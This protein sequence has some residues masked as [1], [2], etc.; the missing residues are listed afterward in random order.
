MGYDCNYKMIFII[1]GN[2]FI[3]S[4]IVRYCQKNKKVYTVITRDNYDSYKG[5]SCS[6]LINANGNS[7]KYLADENPKLE[8]KESVNSVRD[9]LDDFNAKLYIHLSSCDVYPDCS[10]TEST[11]EDACIDISQQSRY[12]FH[13]YLAEQCVQHYAHNWLIIRMGG[14]VGPNLIKNPIFDILAN[15]TLWVNPLS[16]LQYMHT[17]DFSDTLFG[18]INNGIKNQII[19]VCGQGTVQLCDVIHYCNSSSS[20]KQ[21]NPLIEY[22]ISVDKLRNMM[23]IP[24]SKES[25]FKFINEYKKNR[26]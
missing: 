16:K 3:G 17:D 8:F 15:D 18:L 6:I 7:K 1:G 14:F 5:Q 25:V 11:K 21:K 12:G 22:N 26:N 10:D 23:S 9:S 13:K 4:A 20:V 2:G 24:K 19:N